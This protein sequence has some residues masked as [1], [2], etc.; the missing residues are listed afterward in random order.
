MMSSLSG[1]YKGSA[2]YGA[3][4]KD[5]KSGG[6]VVSERPIS[7]EELASTGSIKSEQGYSGVSYGGGSRAVSGGISGV[8]V[9]G[10]SGGYS[11]ISSGIS[12]VTG[13]I[14]GSRISSGVTGGISGLSGGIGGGV[15]GGISGF[16]GGLTSSMGYSGGMSGG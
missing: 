1:A 7:R 2:S 14:S 8:P 3:G 13:G 15:S 5:L 4:P 9:R 16:S 11:G 12:G 10:V 6:K